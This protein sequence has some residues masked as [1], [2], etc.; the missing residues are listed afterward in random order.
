MMMVLR[1]QGRHQYRGRVYEYWPG[2]VFCY[3]PQERNEV[4]LP[5]WEA[6]TEFLW[7]HGWERGLTAQ[8]LR[9]TQSQRG[10]RQR[11]KTLLLV[12]QTAPVGPN[13]LLYPRFIEQTQADVRPLVVH[14]GVE[15]LVAAI[16]DRGYLPVDRSEEHLTR[17]AVR[18]VADFIQYAGGATD[19]A[20]CARVAGCSYSQVSK[21]FIQYHDRFLKYYVADCRMATV[22]KLLG[23]GWKK[24]QIAEYFGMSSASL[25]NWLRRANRRRPF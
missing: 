3:G 11:A 18:M 13:P 19:M 4:E 20:E 16:V 23:E 14:A 6:G 12:D 21:L 25:S 15:L 2:T 22:G 5:E 1:G 8:L 10:W 17:Q 9:C 7:A 24:K